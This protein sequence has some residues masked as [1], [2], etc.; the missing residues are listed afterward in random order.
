LHNIERE[1]N[2]SHHTQHIDVI[3]KS[4]LTDDQIAQLIDHEQ[5]DKA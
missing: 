1:E 5:N 4:E 3:K 2:N